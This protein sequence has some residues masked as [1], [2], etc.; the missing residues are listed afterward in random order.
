MALTQV[1]GSMLSDG[2]IISG[3]SE[4]NATTTLTSANFGQVVY[5]NTVTDTTLTLPALSG[6]NGK[7]IT[8]SNLNTGVVTVTTPSGGI[9]AFGKQGA[10][11]ITL[12]NGESIQLVVNGSNW[13]SLTGGSRKLIKITKAFS[14]STR[15]VYGNNTG[16]SVSGQNF[17]YPTG[18]NQS[19]PFVKESPTSDIVI[20]WQMSVGNF[21]QTHAVLIWK[22]TDAT[23]NKR[24]N[25]DGGNGIGGR[26]WVESGQTVFSG[27]AAGSHTFFY[28]HG[29]ASDGNITGYT[30]NMNAT[31]NADKGGNTISEIL[32]YEY[33]T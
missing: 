6:N 17:T 20:A 12:S 16:G 10:S 30:L 26:G 27:L 2:L 21:Y 5:S 7:I 8:I 1:P 24:L 29:R 13:K 4:Y 22:S 23:V 15:A 9:F 32:V 3:Q 18:G 14:S 28:A 31:D 11:S 33:E 19:I 25:F